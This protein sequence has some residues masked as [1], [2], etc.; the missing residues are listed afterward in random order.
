M[1][2][3]TDLL[4]EDKDPCWKNYKQVGMKT[5]DGKEVPNCV[6]ESV[7]INE[8]SLTVSI[9][10]IIKDLLPKE[11]FK[12]YKPED[13]KRLKSIISDL[14]KN[15][16]KFYKNHNIKTKF[17]DNLKTYSN[18]P[19]YIKEFIEDELHEVVNTSLNE[20]LRKWL[21]SGPKGGWDRYSTTG[22]KLGKCGDAKDG[23]PY[24]ACLSNEKAKKLGKSGIASF[25]R[26]K[27]DAQKKAGDAEK[28]GESK[29][30]QKPVRVK[31]GA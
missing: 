17:I 7:D 24:S 18:R 3:L 28:G 29:K 19:M 4:K 13:K 2:K 31:T 5:K 14:V 22:T 30:G 10:T 8:S 21:G 23:D 15:L 11:I 6:P 20:D 12:V 27:R 1:I 9:A 25:V 16:N 26:R